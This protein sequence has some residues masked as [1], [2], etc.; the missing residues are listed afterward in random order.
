MVIVFVSGFITLLYYRIEAQKA[1]A[2]SAAK[3]V[4]LSNMSHEFRTP[5][6]VILGMGEL[7]RRTD[8]LN[9]IQNYTNEIIAAGQRLLDMVSGLIEYS[10]SG[11]KSSENEPG[12]EK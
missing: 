3:S 1:L 5:L 4:F 7:I 6:N 8:D 12:V 10:H 11:K 9:L 2:A